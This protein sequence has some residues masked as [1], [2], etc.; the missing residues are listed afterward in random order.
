MPHKRILLDTGFLYALF[1]ED[2]QHHAQ[3]VSVVADLVG[4]LLLPTAVLF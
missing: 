4:D 3:V 2:D 1:D